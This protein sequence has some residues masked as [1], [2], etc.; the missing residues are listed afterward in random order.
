MV[1][2]VVDTQM[3]EPEDEL[4]SAAEAADLL[5]LARAALEVIG[6]AIK[7]S[8]EVRES[9]VLSRW[10]VDLE[11]VLLELEPTLTETSMVELAGRLGVSAAQLRST[12][13]R[14]Q[15]MGLVKV[16]DAGV[17]LTA[18]GRQ[19]LAKLE[20]ARAA[21]LRRIAAQ[22]S[23]LPSRQSRQLIT[24]LEQV[25]GQTEQVVD[26]HLGDA[27]DIETAVRLAR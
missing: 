7:S 24:L 9:R 26:K 18:S 10:P 15:R 25:I 3:N 20:M 21:V 23:P 6:R 19:K 2:A 22:L 8:P 17:A 5:A 27:S 11:D 12:S 1:V 4:R 14:L 13:G 16:S